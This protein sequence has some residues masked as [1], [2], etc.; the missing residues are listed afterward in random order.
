MLPPL[1]ALEQILAAAADEKERAKRLKLAE[2]TLKQSQQELQVL[3]T[4]W[5]DLTNQA[6]KVHTDL[7]G[8]VDEFNEL[9]RSLAAKTVALHSRFQASKALLQQVHG[10]SADMAGQAAIYNVPKCS[11]T[12]YGGLSFQ[13]ESSG[14]QPNLGPWGIRAKCSNAEKKPQNALIILFS[15]FFQELRV[16]ADTLAT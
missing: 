11:L 6:T 4:E 5:N 8:L 12:Q 14:L 15:A 16:H 13:H 1:A 7:A 2:Q 3:E 9:S 10:P